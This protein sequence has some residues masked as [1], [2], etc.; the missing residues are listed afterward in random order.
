MFHYRQSTAGL[1][2]PVSTEPKNSSMKGVVGSEAFD[3]KEMGIFVCLG[4][5]A[6]S[7]IETFV[8]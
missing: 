2:F 7:K 3:N 8:S 4:Y 5:E 6:S 1:L